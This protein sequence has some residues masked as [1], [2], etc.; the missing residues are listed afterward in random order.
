M[1]NRIYQN[2]INSRNGHK[3]CAEMLGE[4]L[5]VT[6]DY[7]YHISTEPNL[8][9]IDPAFSTSHNEEYILG[10]ETHYLE[11]SIAFNLYE[12]AEIKRLGGGEII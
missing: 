8:R 2:L 5:E 11:N 10:I 12:F 3:R 7:F 6:R 1:I 9:V 4:S